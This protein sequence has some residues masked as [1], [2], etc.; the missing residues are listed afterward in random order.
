MNI[1]KLYIDYVIKK[2]IKFEK[3]KILI[4]NYFKFKNNRV[5]VL[6]CRKDKL[7][8]IIVIYIVKN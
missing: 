4:V 2:I 5:K 7:Y 6:F 1:Y 8:R 3:F